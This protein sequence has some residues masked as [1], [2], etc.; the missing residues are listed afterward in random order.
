MDNTYK[1]IFVNI[2]S[3]DTTTMRYVKPLAFYKVNKNMGI[4]YDKECK[5][6]IDSDKIVKKKQK[7]IIQTPKM[8]VPFGIK[9]FENNGKKSYQMSL[10]FSSLTNL[11]NENEI[12]DFYKFIRKIDSTNEEIV[13]DHKKDWHLPKD[14][15]YCKSLKK[16]GDY[17]HFIN[18]SLPYDEKNGFLFHTYNENAKKSDIDIIEK[19][20]IVS[21]VLELTDLKFS[22]TEYRAGWTVMQ[23]RRYKPYSPIQEFFMTGCYLCDQDDPEDTVYSEIISRYQK[24]MLTPLPLQ[25]QYIPPPCPPSTLPVP[26]PPSSLQQQQPSVTKSS[27]KPPSLQELLNGKN[28]LKKSKSSI[29]LTNLETSSSAETVPTNDIPDSPAQKT[30]TKKL[31]HKIE[32]VEIEDEEDEEEEIPKKSKKKSSKKHHK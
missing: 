2:A 1:D 20:C 31:K 5:S 3:F 9:K 8:I 15:T 17:P 13:E 29:Q 7:I 4:Y 26:P 12:L 27:F 28:S 18:V 23:I 10:S 19:R 21:V 16:T 14:L 30:A 32:K 6:S 24:A 11:Y 25:M 22:D